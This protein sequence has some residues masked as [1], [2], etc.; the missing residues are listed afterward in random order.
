M[1]KRK[2]EIRIDLNLLNAKPP[3]RALADVTLCYSEGEIKLRRCSVFQKTGE[4]PWANLPGISIEKHGKRQFV[5]VI[6][7]SREQKKSVVDALLDEY[8][9]RT[10]EH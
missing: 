1:D 7:L 5:P 2:P 6:E 4:P 3:L 9:R 10:N 8:R